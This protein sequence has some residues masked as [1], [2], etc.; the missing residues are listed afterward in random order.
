MKAY[1]WEV[2]Q[3][4]VKFNFELL[5]YLSKIVLKLSHVL[6]IQ[7]TDLKLIIVLA[8]YRLTAADG[9]DAVLLR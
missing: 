2:I 8:D 6:Q 9:K 7:I 5:L 3:K 1:F 4:L